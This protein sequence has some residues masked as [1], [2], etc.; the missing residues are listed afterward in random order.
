M[1]IEVQ[2]R[3][4]T[5]KATTAERQMTG[6]RSVTV[7]KE[8]VVIALVCEGMVSDGMWVRLRHAAVFAS[9][10]EAHKLAARIRE[11]VKGKTDL[12]G[13]NLKNWIWGASIT[14]AFTSLQAEPT[15]TEY[16]V[17]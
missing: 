8:Y 2:S 6:C 15:A 17:F 9:E 13:L 5:R 16:K 4:V 11:G 14:N 10:T 1:K 7:G 3:N 12:N